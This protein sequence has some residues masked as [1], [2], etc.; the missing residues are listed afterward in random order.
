MAVI[1][2]RLVMNSSSL[3]DRDTGLSFA[4]RKG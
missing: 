2:V 3:Y 4:S 1:I